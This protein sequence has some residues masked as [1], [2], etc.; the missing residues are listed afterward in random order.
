MTSQ[1]AKFV[2]DGKP[3]YGYL[4]AHI[5]VMPNGRRIPEMFQVEGFSKDHAWKRLIAA[6]P[7]LPRNK[8]EFLSDLEPEHDVGYM[9]EKIPLFP[10]VVIGA[11]NVRRSS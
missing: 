9:G 6:R 8:I 5:I 1:R 4:F 10:A 7:Q 3:V 2:I 11:R